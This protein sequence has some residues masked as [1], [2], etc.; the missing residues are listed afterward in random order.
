MTSN[1][2]ADADDTVPHVPTPNRSLMVRV[3]SNLPAPSRLCWCG[4]FALP[5]D[6]DGRCWWH[7]EAKAESVESERDQ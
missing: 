2:E 7:V 1:R 4:G 5:A 6:P 3:T